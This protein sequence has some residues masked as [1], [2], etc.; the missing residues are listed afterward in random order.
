MVDQGCAESLA[1][2][3]TLASWQSANSFRRNRERP[4]NGRRHALLTVPRDAQLRC[5][6]AQPFASF[7][8]FVLELASGSRSLGEAS[9]SRPSDFTLNLAGELIG[10]HACFA[11]RDWKYKL[12]V[13]SQTKTNRVILM[14]ICC[15]S[16][17]A[18]WQ[19]DFH[20]KR[21]YFED[22]NCSGASMKC[23][24]SRRQNFEYGASRKHRV[25]VG[26]V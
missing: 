2:M 5:A 25:R 10:E 11:E 21:F 22:P 9:V 1:L 17:L 7:A 14:Q 6:N 20:S 13:R 15:S 18:S 23:D 3:R 26:W 4:C 24:G 12:Q 19:K 8:A 16:L